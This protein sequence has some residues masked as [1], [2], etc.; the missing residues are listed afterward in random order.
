[1]IVLKNNIIWEQKIFL[2]MNYATG[3]CI[4][5]Q[6]NVLCYRKMYYAT[7]K[8][9]YATG[10]MYYAKR[11]MYYATGKCIMLQEN[12]LCYRKMYYGT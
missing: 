8:M 12:V 3:K 10:K 5:L 7:G 9:Y 1:M 11:E 4:M 6:E 2:K